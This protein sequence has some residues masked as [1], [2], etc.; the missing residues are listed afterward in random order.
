MI[1][2]FKFIYILFFMILLV[3]TTDYYLEKKYYKECEI[4]KY[5]KI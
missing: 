1:R 5:S 2:P 4:K 3:K